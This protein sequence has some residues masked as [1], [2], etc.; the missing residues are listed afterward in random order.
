MKLKTFLPYLILGLILTFSLFTHTHKILDNPPS[1][2]SDEADASYQAFVFNHQGTDYFGNRL[3][4]HFHSFSDWRTSFYLYSIALTQK[5][6]G[7]TDLS[8]RLPSAIYGTL[9]ILVFFFIIKNIFKSIN[10]ALI[11]AFLFSLSP[12]LIHYSRTGFEVSGM[13][14]TILLGFYFWIKFIN[15]E[16]LRFILFSGVFF[17]SSIYFYSTAKLFL[18]FIA[19]SIYILWFKKINTLSIK[20]KS[21]AILVVFIISLP[22]LIDT[23]RGRAGYR[24]SYINIFSDPT[25]SKTIDYSRLEDSI[26]IVGNDQIG[27]KPSLS[28]K[29]FYNKLSVW[30]GMFINNYFSSF[31]TEFLFLK[32][33]G[34]LRQGFQTS[35][36]LL[37]PDLLFL[38]LGLS[39]VFKNKKNDTQKFVILFFACLLFAPIPFALT[40]DS[41]F[42]H[43]TRLIIMLPFLTFFSLLGIKELYS[44]TKSKSIISFIFFI[45]FLCFLNFTHQ[46]FFHYPNI[47]AR[48]WHLGMKEAVI[49][50]LSNSTRYQR[51]Y[52]SNS[53]EPFMPFFLNYSEYIPNDKNVSPANSFKWDNNNF[54]TGMQAENKYYIGNIE[55]SPLLD[56]QPSPKY[57]FVIPQKDIIR[58]KDSLDDYNKSHKNTIS[59]SKIDEVKKKYTEQENFY[60]LNFNYNQ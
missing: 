20:T 29:F 14:F 47:S 23:I 26:Q 24:F 13:L 52:Y 38:I 32:G 58:L 33:D 1:L 31:S 54:F 51:I 34:N 44:Y 17:I 56:S 18:I 30:S 59:I 35:G 43:G 60:L 28:S 42:P 4:I 16:K 21:I 5:F 48:D 9:T 19:A 15:N 7:H 49:K 37:F 39:S 11:G 40:R 2:F 25:V 3:P 6:I 36:Y 53:Y 55:W 22:F 57:L 46:Y 12:W 8:A 45:Y 50:S 10:W 27:L 41:L